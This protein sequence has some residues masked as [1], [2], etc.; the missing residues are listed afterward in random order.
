MRSS[1]ARRVATVLLAQSLFLS[2]TFAQ[3]QSQ[4]ESRPRRTQPAWPQPAA[5]TPIIPSPNLHV[6]TGPEP[7]IRVALR[8]DVRSGVISSACHLLNATA[9]GTTLLAVDTSRVRVDA[10]LLSPLTAV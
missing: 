4:T 1:L 8:T 3:Q 7:Q 2:L 6:V 5:S 9:R 10:R